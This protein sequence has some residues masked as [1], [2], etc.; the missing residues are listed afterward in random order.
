M[1]DKIKIVSFREHNE[2]V[3]QL[4]LDKIEQVISQKRV[5]IRTRAM[6]ADTPIYNKRGNYLTVYD[7]K[8]ELSKKQLKKLIAMASNES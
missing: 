7:L 6:M 1:D 2:R 4:L 8:K 5:V 3:L